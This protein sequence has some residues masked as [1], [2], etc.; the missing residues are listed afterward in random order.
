VVKQ[1]SETDYS[2][3]A[4]ALTALATVL[5]DAGQAQ[6]AQ[7]ILDRLPSILAAQDAFDAAI[8]ERRLG[9]QDRAHRLF[10][11]AGDLVL[12][13]ARALHEFVQSKM[14][15]T[16]KLVRSQR[17]ADQEVRRRLLEQAASYLERVTQMD[18]P[19]TRH[20][21]AWFDLGRVR[22]WLEHPRNEVVE[23]FQRAVALVPTERRFQD[24]LA[25]AR[26]GKA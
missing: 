26:R 12:R 14:H 5:I 2:E 19:P 11:R 16:V 7:G 8:A 9:R 17:P 1:I 20:A 25:K 18:A 6:E 23:A 24:E 3:F 13:D 4:R 15:L 22:R 10:E 21:W